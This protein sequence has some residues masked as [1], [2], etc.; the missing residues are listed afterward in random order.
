MHGLT[1]RPD[2]T[3][4]IGQGGKGGTKHA[5]HFRLYDATQTR[6]GLSNY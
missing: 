6:E 1:H 5:Q 4:H 2:I 3:I